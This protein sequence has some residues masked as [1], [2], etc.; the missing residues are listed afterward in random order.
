[1]RKILNNQ[2]GF[3][4]IELLLAIVVAAVLAAIAISGYMHVQST[5]ATAGIVNNIQ[6]FET[7]ADQYSAMNSGSFVGMNAQALQNDGLLPS[8]WTIVS[9]GWVNPPNQSTVTQYGISSGWLGLGSSYD[10]G[11][12]GNGNSITDAMVHSICLDFENKITG[13]RYNGTVTSVTTGGADCSV[14]PTD[15]NPISSTAG[16]ILGF[17]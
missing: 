9:G 4:L 17:E 8:G 14:I 7:I 10:I 6:K 11:F 12:Y 2:D 15:N 3:T 5:A 13:F 1:M 16:F